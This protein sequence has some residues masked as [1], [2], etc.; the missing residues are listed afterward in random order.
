MDKNDKFLTTSCDP[1]MGHTLRILLYIS[2]EKG[3][4][5]WFLT[6][7]LEARIKKMLKDK[8]FFSNL[9]LPDIMRKFALK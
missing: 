6:K 4:K 2:P 5:T 7:T 9:L 1:Y 8:I 3:H